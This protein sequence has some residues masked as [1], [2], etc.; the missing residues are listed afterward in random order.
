M[1]T[2]MNWIDQSGPGFKKEIEKK[3]VKPK[4]IYTNKNKKSANRPPKVISGRH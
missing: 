2:K 1:S 3:Q 4:T